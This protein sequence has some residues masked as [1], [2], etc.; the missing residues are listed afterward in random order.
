M[1]GPRE[2]EIAARS[3]DNECVD[4]HFPP[5]VGA[6]YP[7]PSNPP[8]NAALSV[9]W[10]RPKGALYVHSE[11]CGDVTSGALNDA[12][13]LGAL[14]ILATRRELLLVWSVAEGALAASFPGGTRAGEGWRGAGGEGGRALICLFTR[15]ST[16]RPL[17]V[18]SRRF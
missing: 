18:A 1:E 3:V 6:I 15:F 9:Q 11:S 5:T 17:P 14:G 10:V 16:P 13:M 12:W 7:D 2:D 4:E 8:T